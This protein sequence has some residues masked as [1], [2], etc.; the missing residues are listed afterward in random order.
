LSPF[1]AALTLE[2]VELAES[3]KHPGQPLRVVLAADTFPPDINGAARFAERLAGGLVRNGNDVH[4]IAPATSKQWGTFREVHDGIEMTVH[5]IQSHRVLIHKTLRFIWAPSLKKR[6]DLILEGFEPDAIH[7]QSHLVLGRVLARSGKEHGIRLIATNHIM[8]ENLVKY[9]HLPRPLERWLMKKLWQDSG[10]VLRKYDHITT[11]TRRAAE[12]L[13][14]AANVS[15]VLA[16]SCGIDASIFTNETPTTNKPMRVLFLGRLDY[17]KHIHNLL[18]A[19]AK[20]PR[21]LNT[22]V[23]IAGDGSQRKYLGDLAKSLGIEANVKFLGHISEEELPLA[24]ERA[25]V[26]AMPSIA[27]LQSIATMEAMASGRPV[28][29]AN[30]MALP[31][32]VHDGDNGY[33]FEPDDVDQFADRLLHIATADQDELDRLSENSVHL[34]QAHDIARTLKIFEGLYRGDADEQQTS[35]DN[36]EEYS[37]PIGRL[38]EAVRQ[39]ERLMRR[40]TL[41]A[42]GKMSGLGDEIESFE[43]LRDGVVSRAK[44]VDK[45]VRK[46]VKKTVDQAKS[47]LKGNDE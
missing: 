27:E 33:L 34:I 21:E 30:A 24:Y 16:I 3:I 20:L 26:F 15:G 39:M 22:Q 12:L 43:D 23:E 47:R 40:R 25:T 46:S 7:S 31:H 19:V 13:E 32:L 37:L 9:L 2:S 1:G 18:K 17:E 29:A 44:R 5:R 42:I 11:P 28:I 4:V 45:R 41:I 10:R 35:D 36:L 8:P 14:E 38:N 6:V